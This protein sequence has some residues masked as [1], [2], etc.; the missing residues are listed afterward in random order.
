MSRQGVTLMCYW[1]GTTM[2]GPHGISYEGA[3]P[4]PIRVG[5]GITH[6]ELIDRIYGVTGFDKQSFKLKIICRYPA[7]R[8]YIPV[9]ID[10]DESIDIMFDV[11]RQPGTNCL[12]L[13]V[14]KEPLCNHNPINVP[15]PTIVDNQT[16]DE[17]ATDDAQ[18]DSFL[19]PGPVDNSIL[20][21]QNQHRSEAI[22]MGED[23]SVLTCRQRLAAM[24]KDWQ[25]DPR[26]R[27]LIIKAGFYGVY[28]VGILQI[29]WPLITAL[30]ERWRQETHTF[31]FTV[32]ESTV[33]LQDVALLLGL[34]VNGLVVTGNTD[35]QW[36]DLCEELLGLRPDSSV[37]HGSALK[38]SW[39]RTHFQEPTSDADDVTLQRYA[40]A[41][42]LSLMGSV[43][44]AD[45]SG[46][47]VQLMFLPFL[48][49]LECVEQFSWGSA[50]LAHLYRELC[51]ASK[52][53]A[54]EISGPLVLLQIWA[55]ERLDISR[56]ERLVY[57]GR[58]SIISD[59]KAEK[60]RSSIAGDAIVDNE[61]L[62][63]DPLGCRD[64]LDQQTES[65][66][67]WQPYI[68]ERLAS[69]PDSLLRDQHVWRTVA[70][71]IC[72]D[73]VEW[74]H[75]ERVLRQFGLHQEIPQPC[76]TETKLHT[77]DRR[78]KH[79]YDWKAYHGQYIKLWEGREKSI[80]TGKLEELPMQ[81]HDP[82]MVWYRNVTRR[83]IT[84]LTQ[85]SHMRFQP[86]SGTS[87]LLVQSLTTI[88]NQCACALE[89]FTSD[90]AMKSLEC[91]QTTCIRVLQMIGE[92]R[93]LKGKQ[94]VISTKPI[95]TIPSS[96]N[97]ANNTENHQH[98]ECA[99]PSVHT[100]RVLTKASL[101]RG[102]GRSRGRGRPRGSIK[103]K[104]GGYC[105]AQS[106]VVETSSP[107]FLSLHSTSE[108]LQSNNGWD[109]QL[110]IEDTEVGTMIEPVDSVSAESSPESEKTC[111]REKS[112]EQSCLMY[113][114]SK[115]DVVVSPSIRPMHQM[116]GDKMEQSVPL[117]EQEEKSINL[118][119]K[120]DIGRTVA[121]PNV[122]S[123]SGLCDLSPAEQS[124]HPTFP[125]KR[126]HI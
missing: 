86:S 26:V 14:E 72:F 97:D 94:S 24:M 64:L 93:H 121:L 4:K 49:D 36:E 11:A 81:Y 87:H 23:P 7:C 98:G 37:L 8:E 12:E 55:W 10:D 61:Q 73:I 106:V 51:R 22:W 54:N 65:Q 105:K 2:S 99:S 1:N 21:L 43:L 30:V 20:V 113:K 52:K 44:F 40:R 34:P 59:T 18:V 48:R 74:H 76:D 60:E 38:V 25:L 71:L 67:V 16:T 84:P 107:S 32:G 82:Y 116:K 117:L 13:Y 17:M 109:R 104:G 119:G 15:E 112:P 35:L 46:A 31:H 118:L 123:I 95:T 101:V 75:P 90:G 122:G 125:K 3:A 100:V 80:A 56:P 115:R 33:T 19:D 69:L 29:D 111:V 70:P 68:S 114:E 5:Y 79:H 88:H 58:K 63:A 9:P 110:H 45:K 42:I 77:I 83:L 120:E 96:T 27:Q 41:Y 62:P 103:S 28:R 50:V 92:T 6:N 126:K 91:I 66:M 78:G 102:Q 108:S 39:L 89:S 47:D 85:R 57:K 53:G 124:G